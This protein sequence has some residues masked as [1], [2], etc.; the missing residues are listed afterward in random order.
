MPTYP[1]LCGCGNR[2]DVIRPI[3][4]RD[5]PLCCLTCGRIMTR[6]I[7]APA[8][9]AWKTDRK[10]PNTTEYGDGSRSFDSKLDY[11]VYLK[12]NHLGESATDAPK[13]VRLGHKR[14]RVG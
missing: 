6:T 10:F 14:V 11:N 12:E 13:K 5:D 1:Y 4:S 9:Q 2:R 8:V 3:D 7:S